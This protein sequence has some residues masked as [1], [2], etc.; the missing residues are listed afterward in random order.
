MDTFTRL[1]AQIRLLFF[2]F[3]LTSYLSRLPFF[4]RY[5]TKKQIKFN[6]NHNIKSFSSKLHF[7]G[8]C[9]QSISLQQK[10]EL[11]D[12]Y[13]SQYDLVRYVTLRN[14]LNFCLTYFFLCIELGRSRMPKLKEYRRAIMYRAKLHFFH[15]RNLEIVHTSA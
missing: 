6:K 2:H 15:E 5:V 10:L 7:Q 3:Q 1:F 11:W 8:L 13:V 4:V 12:V 9:N 14:A